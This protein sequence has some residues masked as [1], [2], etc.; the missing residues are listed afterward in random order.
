LLRNGEGRDA[1]RRFSFA[2]GHT[3]VPF[4]RI[5]SMIRADGDRTMLYDLDTA[6]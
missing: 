1:F 2:S 3:S 6:I 5:Q 4:F